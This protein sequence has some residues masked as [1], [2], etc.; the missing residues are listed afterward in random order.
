[1]RYLLLSLM[2]NLMLLCNL[3]LAVSGPQQRTQL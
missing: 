3:T 1:M 2:L